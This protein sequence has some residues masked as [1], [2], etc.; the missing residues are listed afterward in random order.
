VRLRLIAAA[1]RELFRIAFYYDRKAPGLG[2]RFL[3]DVEAN[4]RLIR[5][6]PRSAA[7]FGKGHRCSLDTFPYA[8]LYRIDGDEVVVIAI[9]HLARGPRFWRNV[10]R[11]R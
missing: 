10:S 5:S 3:E 2:D 8:V 4:V 11:R 1:K 6:Y 7:A 9:G